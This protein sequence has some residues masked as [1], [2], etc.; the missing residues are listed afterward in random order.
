MAKKKVADK[1]SVGDVIALSTNYTVLAI[2]PLDKDG[3]VLNDKGQAEVSLTPVEDHVNHLT[4]KLND[5]PQ[6]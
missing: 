2:G 6:Q 3:N 4:V 5:I 1:I